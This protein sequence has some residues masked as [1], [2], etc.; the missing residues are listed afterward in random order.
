MNPTLELIHAHRSIRRYKPEPIPEQHI[1]EAV[2]AGQA[3]STSSAIQGASVLR[4][5]DESARR[6]LVALTGGQ[7]KVAAS[8]AFLVICAD[9]RRHRL[10]CARAGRNYNAHLEAFL[11]GVI[12]ASLLAQNMTVA[13]ESMGYGVCYI[14]GLRN[15]LQSVDALLRIPHG[16]YPLFGLCAG[17]P[18]ESPQARPRLPLEAVLFDDRYPDDEA[19]LDLLAEYDETYRTY[20]AARGVSDAGKRAAA[21]SGPMALKFSEP[22]RD[23][24]GP[25]YRGKGAD[26]S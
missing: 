20:L 9:T 21:W 1:R 16:V 12:D 14:G 15:D 10:L 23:D 11:L 8:G 2:R 24:V 4:I 5:T 19:M 13:L 17:V 26:F 3:A 18:D 6:R 7:E 22:R 25:Y